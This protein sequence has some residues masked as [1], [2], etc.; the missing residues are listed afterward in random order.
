MAQCRHQRQ[1]IRRD[2]RAPR[3]HE[4]HAPDVH[5]ARMV[6]V[7]EMHQGQDAGYVPATTGAP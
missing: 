1:M 6:D 2:E 7:I 3:A 5:R 4:L